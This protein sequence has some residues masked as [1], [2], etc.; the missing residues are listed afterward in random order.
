[1]AGAAFEL[2]SDIIVE[3]SAQVAYEILD[4]EGVLFHEG[5]S[6]VYVLN[7]TATMIWEALDGRST[8]GEIVAEFQRLTGAPRATIESDVLAALREFSG[9]ALVDI[10]P[11]PSDT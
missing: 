11:T 1:M 4:G 5:S 6:Q 10:E 7:L 9:S 2:T 8:I 3:R